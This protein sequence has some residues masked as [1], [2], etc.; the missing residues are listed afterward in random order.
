LTNDGFQ[1]LVFGFVW[2][3]ELFVAV[4]KEIKMFALIIDARKQN[5]LSLSK[6]IDW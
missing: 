2:N 4:S 5:F 1:H 6:V 3:E